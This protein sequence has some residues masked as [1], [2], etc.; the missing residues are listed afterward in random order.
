MKI[1]IAFK[2]LLQHV[3]LHNCRG[4]LIHSDKSTEYFYVTLVPMY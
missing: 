2:T 1:R 4:Y 3:H